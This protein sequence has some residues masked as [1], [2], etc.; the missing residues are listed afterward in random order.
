MPITFAGAGSHAP[1]ITA[2]TEAAPTNQKDNFFAGYDRLR[3]SL[4]ASGTEVLVL[5]TSE[6]WA[7]FF[8]DH[9][10]PYCVGLAE[11]FEGPVEPWLRVNRTRVPGDAELARQIVEACYERGIEPSFSHELE[12]DHGSMVPLHMLTP[13]MRVPVVPVLF[14]TLSAPQPPAWRCRDL[15]IAASCARWPRAT[16][17]GCR[18]TRGRNSPRRARGRSSSSAGLPWPAR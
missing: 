5:L 17:T 13:S 18:A 1:G 3:R 16:S 11:S 14:N 4:E 12:L 2:W 7:N 9:V 10:S 8:L 15:S 6:H